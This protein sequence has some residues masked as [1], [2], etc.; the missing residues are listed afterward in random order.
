[1]ACNIAEV[2]VVILKLCESVLFSNLFH[3][4]ILVLLEDEQKVKSGGVDIP[5]ILSHLDHGI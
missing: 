1:M 4:F 2:K 5:W 3:R